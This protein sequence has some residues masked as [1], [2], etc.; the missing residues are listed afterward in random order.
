[1]VGVPSALNELW[2]SRRAAIVVRQGQ[3]T[4][5]FQRDH[6]RPPTPVEALKLAQQATLETRDAKH[7]PRTVTQQRRTWWT[8]ARAVLGERG[9]AEMVATATSHGHTTTTRVTEQW[10]DVTAAEIV[11]AVAMSRATRETA[12]PATRLTDATARY[13]DTLHLATETTLDPNVRHALHGPS[14]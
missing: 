8:E 3:L 13:L 7:E 14:R 10:I 12:T 1:M 6:H 2:S 11:S 9:I 4:S 5:A